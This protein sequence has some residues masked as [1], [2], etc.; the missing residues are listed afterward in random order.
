MQVSVFQAFREHWWALIWALALWWCTLYFINQFKGDKKALYN[1]FFFSF[2]CQFVAWAIFLEF[3]ILSWEGLVSK[4][5][6]VFFGKSKSCKFLTL[7]SKSFFRYQVLIK[8]LENSR[9][10]LHTC[11]KIFNELF[12]FQYYPYFLSSLFQMGWV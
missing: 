12:Q 9:I 10:H 7:S 6:W 3:E 5:F 8:L 11:L 4:I 2:E 1:P